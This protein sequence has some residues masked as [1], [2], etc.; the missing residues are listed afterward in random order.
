LAIYFRILLLLDVDHSLKALWY[1]NVGRE[2]P[3]M[4][5]FRILS[6]EGRDRQF[7]SEVFIRFCLEKPLSQSAVDTGRIRNLWAASAAAG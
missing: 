1:G 7:L 3:S 2:G 5:I 6:R 4:E